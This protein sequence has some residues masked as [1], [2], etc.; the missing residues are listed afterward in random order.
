[1]MYNIYSGGAEG[2]DVT[3]ADLA[4]DHGIDPDNI[5]HYYVSGFKTPHGNTPIPAVEAM[6][7]ADSLVK[8]VNRKYLK[9][10]FPSS[11]KY[12]NNL[13]RRNYY[14]VSKAEKTIAV[15]TLDYYGVV[16]GGTAWACYMGIEMGVD[17]VVYDQKQRLTY[18]WDY[19]ECKFKLYNDVPVLVAN[20]ALIG[21]RKLNTNGRLFMEKVI[22]TTL[23]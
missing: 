20:T 3:W 8:E 15:S 7:V 6:V 12:I 14:Q 4:V 17:T 23:K 16:D 1:M 9:R 19:G 13:I 21:S 5:K 2:A 18:R 10:K 22:K 11:N